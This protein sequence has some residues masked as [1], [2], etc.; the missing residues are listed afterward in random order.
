VTDNG[1]GSLI[2][3]EIREGM[4][5]ISCVVSNEALDPA[6]GLTDAGTPADMMWPRA[7]II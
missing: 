1:K 2:R 5:R 4:R 6:S 3:F 7:V